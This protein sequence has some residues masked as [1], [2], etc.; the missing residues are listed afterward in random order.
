M[1][2]A[3]LTLQFLLELVALAGLGYWGIATGGGSFAKVALAVGPPLLAAIARSGCPGVSVAMRDVA[4]PY[5]PAAVFG[6]SPT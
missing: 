1:A 4:I 5:F 2:T 6:G 3:S